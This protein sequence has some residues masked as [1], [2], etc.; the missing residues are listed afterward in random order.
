MADTQ[1]TTIIS[2]NNLPEEEGKLIR[3]GFEG[4][5]SV[6]SEWGK[7]AKSIVVTS[8]DQTDL[9]AEAKE[10][11]KAMQE[12]RKNI[13]E[14]HKKLKE[15]ALRKGQALDAVKRYYLSLIEPIE[16]YLEAQS[17][18]AE[19][20]EA[21]RKAEKLES[22]TEE[23]SK[24]IENLEIYNLE[25]MS[26]EAFDQLLADA[27]KQHQIKLDE[28][29]KLEE[30]RIQKEKAEKLEQERVRKE[31]EKLRLENEKKEKALQEQKRLQ[32]EREAKIKANN[33][34]KLQK[35]KEVQ[36]AKF[37]KEREAKEKLERELKAKK[38]AEAKKLKE[39][40]ELRKM[41]LADQKKLEL[42]PDK[43]KLQYFAG[44]LLATEY[45][46]V[47]SEEA[48]KIVAGIKE[49]MKKVNIYIIEN[50]ENL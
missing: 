36:E 35:Q 50:I 11:K 48:K 47:K 32:A 8:E 45:P 3:S 49:L 41:L 43:N 42:A 28:A 13:T 7:K 10:G 17:K 31:N 29:K 22:R 24:Y 16:E 25:T 14:T 9:M 39:E 18:F 21:K 26:D 46:E 15:V 27:K 6:V 38:D 30:E 2:D 37:R 1:I 12:V 20:A 4:F 44:T 34:A 19:I 40:E 33:E 5:E 23:L